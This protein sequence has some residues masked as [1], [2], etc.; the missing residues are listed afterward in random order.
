ML[1]I[2]ARHLSN[3]CGCGHRR[4]ASLA[5]HR[6]LRSCAVWILRVHAPSPEVV[7]VR[8]SG[9]IHGLTASIL[10]QRIGKQLAR[11]S[12]VVIDLGEVTA[13]D[14]RGLALLVSLHDKATATGTQIHLE[15]YAKASL[16]KCT[17]IAA[18]NEDKKVF[19]GLL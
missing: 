6:F 1:R 4:P 17:P 7:I 14:L 10:A 8:V 5:H 18:R 16:K 2:R 3:F 15:G 11:A 12:H 13:V 19:N 9:G